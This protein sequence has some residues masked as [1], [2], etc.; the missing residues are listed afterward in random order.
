MTSVDVAEIGKNFDEYLELVKKGEEVVVTE[1]GVVVAQIGPASARRNE[2]EDEKLARLERT[3]I[4]VRN[5]TGRI[6]QS[7]IDEP[8]IKLPEGVSVLEALLDERRTAKW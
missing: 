8:P 4:I 3:G 5:G 2:T 6:P 7:L 1:N